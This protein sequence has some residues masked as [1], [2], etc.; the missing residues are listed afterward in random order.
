MTL[1]LNLVR[2][3]VAV[4]ERGSFSAAAAAVHRTQAA[5]T[6]QVQRLEER[7]GARLLARTSREVA[8]TAA[9]EHFIHHAR[10]LLHQSAEALASVRPGEARTPFETWLRI[11][12]TDDLAATVLLPVLA[13]IRARLPGTRF[14]I[15]TGA[16]RELVNGLGSRFDAVLGIAAARSRQGI[17]VA[18][19]G[20][21]WFGAWTPGS[22]SL[23]DASI[24][25]ALYPEGCLMRQLGTAALDEAGLRWR[26]HVMSASV[27]AISASARAGMAVAVLLDHPGQRDGLPRTAGL[28]VLPDV[29]VRLFHAGSCEPALV[30]LIAA[31]LERAIVPAR[32]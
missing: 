19:A 10:R 18:T 22:A 8:L 14:E 30:D 2:T 9:G 5:V 29:E 3:F 21:G 17:R 6:Q 20:L 16:T 24:P 7:V 27:A 12:A 11:G 4:A 28:P 15:A 31:G 23:D 26:P 13:S 32:C 25:L 1:D